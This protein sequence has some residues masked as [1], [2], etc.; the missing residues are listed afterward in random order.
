MNSEPE[1]DGFEWGMSVRIT[2]AAPVTYRAGQVGS[3]VGFR[4]VRTA[5]AAATAGHPIGTLLYIV[6]FGDGTDQEVPAVHCARE[7]SDRQA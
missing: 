7:S 5:A 4:T 1:P 3:V 6:E 2:A